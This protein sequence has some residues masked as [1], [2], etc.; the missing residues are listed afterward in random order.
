LLK[1][2]HMS[3]SK[4]KAEF[5]A[6]YASR[7]PNLDIESY[8]SRKNTPVLLF[9]P[10]HETELRLMFSRE[11]LSW[12]PYR[13]FPQAI[14]RPPEAPTA[15]SL[16]GFREGWLYSLNPSSL[17]PVLA[18]DPQPEDAILD[19]SAAPGGKTLAILN[20]TYPATP[21]LVTN[22]VSAQRCKQLAAT[23]KHFGYPEIPVLHQPVQTLS[24]TLKARFDKIL[25]D[26]PC[27]G[28]KHV[29]NSKRFL[30]IW[31]PKNITKMAT[32]Q[33][34]LLESLPPLLKP[35]GVLVYS[36]CALTREENE[37][38]ITSL[39]RKYADLRLESPMRRVNDPNSN[40]DPMFVATV[41]K[42][43]A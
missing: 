1:L 39:L 6:F 18:L 5:V 8:L 20:F 16:P 28:E 35:R 31:S 33:Q 26:A 9:S 15:D 7:F 37:E 29:F 36:T 43:Q 14:E 19:A 11:K 3:L 41:A 22:D 27:S 40:Y 17:L 32:L 24:T 34:T 38:Q 2:A 10:Q 30:K 21:V 42:K 13:A 12:T 23:L 25:L 4:N